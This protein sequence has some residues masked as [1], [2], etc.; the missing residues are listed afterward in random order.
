MAPHTIVILSGGLS[1]ERDVSLRSGRRIADSLRGR[2]LD[3]EVM[4]VDDELAERLSSRRPTCVIPLVHG[5][6]GEDGE[7][8]A[9]IS[10]LDLPHVGSSAD[11]CRRAFNKPTANDVVRS[12]GIAV[13]AFVVLEQQDFRSKGPTEVLADVVA[14]LGLPLIVKPAQGG[15]SLGVSL[16]HTEQESA[17]GMVNA[18]AYDDR[19]VVQK[20]ISGT[21]V[22]VGVLQTRDG[23]RA[24]PVIEIHADGGVYDYDA[25]YTAG[26]TE[27]TVPANLSP[28]ILATCAQVAITVHTALGL[29]HWSR[30][31][32]IVDPDGQVWFL[33][34]NVSP[35]MTETSTYPQAVAAAGLQ[36]GAV[37]EELIDLVLVNR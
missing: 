18:F 14:Q 20:Y 25:R 17:S 24:L 15:S 8:A 26:S 35:G 1:P 23:L 37:V 4:D 2:D 28:A 30:S 33:E 13:P 34:V 12:A 22:T 9:L 3:V 29:R 36:M 11:G 27:F 16:V 32:L 7:L 19:V 10:A 6:A 21:E 31:D 5:V